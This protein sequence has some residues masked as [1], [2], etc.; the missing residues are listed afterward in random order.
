VLRILHIELARRGAGR[1]L[2]VVI[3]SGQGEVI[4]LPLLNSQSV[5]SEKLIAKE[6]DAVVRKVKEGVCL[7]HVGRIEVA[8]VAAAVVDE[9]SAILST[10][11]SPTSQFLCRSREDP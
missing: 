4:F 1:I 2:E 7:L 3:E 11:R 5:E 9:K 8:A 6:F 10:G